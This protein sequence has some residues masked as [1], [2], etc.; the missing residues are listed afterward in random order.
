MKTAV[1]AEAT[2]DIKNSIDIANLLSRV[3]VNFACL[4]FNIKL[5][6]PIRHN[7]EKLV[8]TKLKLN[9]IA[10]CKNIVFKLSRFCLLI[11]LSRLN[12]IYKN[13]LLTN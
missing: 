10:K 5:A 13:K 3:L 8:F 2:E 9:L 11:R 12:L 6:L 7:D 1:C 4:A